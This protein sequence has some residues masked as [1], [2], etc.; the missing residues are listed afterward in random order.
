MKMVATVAMPRDGLKILLYHLFPIEALT[1]L[2]LKG[3]ATK[4]ASGNGL[5]RQKMDQ[6]NSKLELIYCLIDLV[7][8]NFN[9]YENELVHHHEFI[10]Q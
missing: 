6:L 8:F 3:V 2:T 10:I 9:W 5:D 4:G 1:T 7:T